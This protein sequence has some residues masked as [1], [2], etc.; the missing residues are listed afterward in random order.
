VTQNQVPP[1]QDPRLGLRTAPSSVPQEEEKDMSFPVSFWIFPTT[2]PNGLPA[3]S[4]ICFSNCTS[5]VPC[6]L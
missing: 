2:P 3:L 4:S 1:E 5:Q 6:E